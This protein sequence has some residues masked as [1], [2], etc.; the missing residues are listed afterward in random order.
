MSFSLKN[1]SFSSKCCFRQKIMIYSHKTTLKGG[2][3][4]SV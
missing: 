3:S 2:V 1:V 4:W